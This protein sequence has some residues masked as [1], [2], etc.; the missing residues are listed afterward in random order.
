MSLDNMQ[1]CDSSLERAILSTMMFENE[2]IESIEERI[3]CDDFFIADHKAIFR[4]ILDLNR[5]GKPADEM[6][7]KSRILKSVKNA[8]DAMISVIS[9]SPLSILS[10]YI[11]ELKY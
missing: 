8:E 11:D 3:D 6:F 9:S 7:V 1:L 5:E 2:A 10:P 4:A